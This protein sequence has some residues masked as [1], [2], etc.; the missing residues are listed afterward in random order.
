MAKE[1][2]CQQKGVDQVEVD[3]EG[4]EVENSDDSDE[5]ID[6]DEIILGNTTDVIMSIAKAFGD[7]FVPY[8]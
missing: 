2:F 5:D 4:E 1:T 3:S 7:S 6:H 8:L